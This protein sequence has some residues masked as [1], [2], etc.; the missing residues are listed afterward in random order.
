MQ[1]GTTM[2]L[3]SHDLEEAVYLADQVLLLTKRPTQDR[4]DPALR[5]SAPAHGGD[6][7]GAEL[8][9]HQEAQP[10]DL[11]A[12]SAG[13]ER[14]ALDD[15]RNWHATTDA[16]S[17]AAS[18]TLPE[19]ANGIALPPTD[20]TASLRSPS[21]I[22]TIAARA[23]CAAR[24]VRNRAGACVSTGRP[25]RDRPP[26]SDRRS[27]CASGRP[28]LRR[29]AEAAAR[30]DRARS[31][32]ASTPS[33]HVT[34]SARSA[35]SARRS[36][37]VRPAGEAPRR[38]SPACPIAVEEPLRRRGRLTTLAGSQ[39]QRRRPPATR[40]MRRWCARMRDARRG[41]GRRA[42]HGRVCAYGFTTENTHYGADAQSARPRRASPAAPP[43][44]PARPWPRGLVPLALG[45]DTNG[46][47]RVPSSLCGVWG[48]KPTFGRLSRHRTFHSSRVP[49]I[50]VRS[51]A[52]LPDLAACYDALQGPDADDPARAQRAA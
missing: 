10:G 16:A 48:L 30:R 40:A 31:T 7:V 35:R 39:D 28:A 1:T 21:G 17:I 22:A 38:R 23:A 26:S 2:L 33:P 5:R 13:A 12:R 43:A 18:S 49:I 46:S 4:R 42:Q 29:V 27:R 11:P 14:R 44:A 8:H 50:S 37:R 3:V 41:S 52:T 24:A 25:R 32:R 20:A 36:M 34:A 19:R 15:V 51:A 6:A 9:R 45:S 47:I